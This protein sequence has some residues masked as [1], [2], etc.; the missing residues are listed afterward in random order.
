MEREE[1]KREGEKGRDDSGIIGNDKDQTKFAAKR[2]QTEEGEE[3]L[4]ISRGPFR[5]TTK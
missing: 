5:K 1:R 2:P 4:R 3:G